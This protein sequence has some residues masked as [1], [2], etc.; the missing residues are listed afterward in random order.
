MLTKAARLGKSLFKQRLKEIKCPVLLTGSLSDDM[1]PNIE[2]CM[3]NVAKQ[4]FSSKIVF[5]PTGAHPLMWSDRVKFR[6]EVINFI[7]SLER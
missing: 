3:G 7:G 5:Y 2:K 1:I 6:K 4:I